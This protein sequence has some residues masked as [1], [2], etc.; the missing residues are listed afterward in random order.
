M[1]AWWDSREPRERGLLIVLGG[2][3]AI[4]LIVF[5]V[6]LPVHGAQSRAQTQLNRAQTDLALVNRL[7][8]R[9]GAVQ[10][11]ATQPFNRSILFQTAQSQNIKIARVQPGEDGAL[12]V[13]VDDVE[14]PVFYAW[15]EDMMSRYRVGMDRMAISAN[16]NGGLSAQFTLLTL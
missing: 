4:F 6:I 8:P 5:A 12:S 1:R 11:Q 3:L 16:R 7:A 13:W 14:S 9:L 10:G 2:L 15:L